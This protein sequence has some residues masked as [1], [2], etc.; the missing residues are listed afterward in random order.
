MSGTP[1]KVADPALRKK[2][3]KPDERL[4]IIIRGIEEGKSIRGIAHEIGCD[5]K[6]IARDLR[7]LALPAEQ[8]AAIQEGDSAEKYLNAALLQETGVDWNVRNKIGR[9][10]REDDRDGRHSDALAQGLLG[11][12]ST[13]SLT[14]CKTDLVLMNAIR[15]RPSPP[16]GLPNGK[17]RKFG[18]LVAPVER[19]PYVDRRLTMPELNFIE[20]CATELARGLV[21]V[22]PVR[23]I[24]Q[25]ALRKAMQSV[26]SR[27]HWTDIPEWQDEKG[28]IAARR[29]R[30]GGK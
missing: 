30:R 5:D 15:W 21:R 22:E 24:R 17:S 7:K 4:P 9:R 12:L 28:K 1:N 26:Q 20:Q 10:R 27:P 8:L 23:A 11:W 25:S 29:N 14:D 19:D 13:K 2:C 16:D 18:E 3:P 6:T